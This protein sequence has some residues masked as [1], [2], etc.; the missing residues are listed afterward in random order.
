MFALSMDSG[1]LAA[2]HDN[3]QSV[4]I[5]FHDKYKTGNSFIFIC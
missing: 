5:C 2:Q 1:W 3:D 4:N